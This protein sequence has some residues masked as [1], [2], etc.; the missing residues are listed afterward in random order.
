MGLDVLLGAALAARF[1]P[2]SRPV[3]FVLVDSTFGLTDLL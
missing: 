3:E 2:V 1:S